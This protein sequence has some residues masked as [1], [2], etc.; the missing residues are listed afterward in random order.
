MD[1]DKALNRIIF[2]YHLDRYYPHYKNMCEAEVILRNIIQNIIES[3]RKVIFVGDSRLG[4]DYVRNISRDYANI[5]FLLYP[6]N[7]DIELCSLENVDWEAYEQIY[8]IS[9]YGAEYIKRWFRRHNIRYEWIYDIFEQGGA[10]F[11]REFYVFGQED[12]FALFDKDR[13]THIRHGYTGAVQCE[14]YCQKNTYKSTQNNQT[15][16]IALEKC[17]FLTLYMRN[18]VAAKEYAFLLSREDEKFEHL[19]SE[20][21]ELLNNVKNCLRSRRQKDIILYWLD[22]IPYGDE[23][24]MLYLQ[25][26]M[27]KSIVFENAYTYIT[28]TTPT[29][30]TLFLGKRD[31]SD[32]AYH[33]TDITWENSPVMQ[34]LREN[35]F[36]IKI[37]SGVFRNYFPIQC[38]SS[39]FYMN[40][41][42]PC[43]M[44]M[45]DMLSNMLKQE[46]KTLY[47]VHCMDSH[48]P[49]LSCKMSDDNYM[50][51]QELYRL[52]RLE[53]DEQ[54]A[55]YDAFLHEEAYRIYMSDHGQTSNAR[56]HIL[57]NIYHKT[58]EPKKIGELFSL[59]DFYTV[60]KQLII[61]GSI[62]EQ[63]FVKEYVEIGQM[64]RYS[65]PDIA[66]IF[67]E[68]SVLTTNDF[69]FKGIIDKEYIYLRYSIKKEWLQKWD[70]MPLCNPLLFFDCE[71]D[72]CEPKLL[73]HYR[74]L[75]GE[76]PTD[77]IESEKFRYSKYLYDLYYNIKKNNDLGHRIAIINRLFSLYSENSIGVRGGGYHSAVLY[78]ILSEE[79]R[80]KIWGF[81][82]NNNKCI[83][84]RFHLP[85]VQTTQTNEL[86]NVG[87][88]AIVLSS[89]DW[90][91]SFR[92]ESKTW[93]E[94]IDILDIYESFEKNGIVCKTNFYQALGTDEDYNV[95]FPFEEVKQ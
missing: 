58:L 69:G 77:I 41:F 22:A 11:Q 23:S 63:E 55:F 39:Q 32:R 49:F 78:H 84:S 44:R 19:W 16:R 35:E 72:V 80:R 8:L 6:K 25:N 61:D 24:E 30:R 34:L 2:K 42:E 5:H 50:N 86:K 93:S 71:N 53:L 12:M 33:I 28:Y 29:L 74:K 56:F 17:L 1:I 36:D 85:I 7:D 48:F 81:I 60:L 26:I 79:N 14:L 70:N 66:K 52:A 64:D 18:F 27:D 75:V 43:S 94:D 57:F 31:V 9:L 59:L 54:L 37:I 90:L 68:K 21:Q 73:Q 13:V 47:L 89:Y 87:V 88:K 65:I 15:K 38:T 62:V 10:F 20:V 46:K 91:D 83:C 51:K 67:R 3:K 40:E 76:Y 92:E 95:G 45:W 82:D 4:I